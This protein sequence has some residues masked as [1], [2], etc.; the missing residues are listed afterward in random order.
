MVVVTA[1]LGAGCNAIFGIELGT[2]SSTSSGS[3]SSSSGGAGGGSSASSSGATGGNGSSTTTSS[4]SGSGGAGGAPACPVEKVP[5]CH[6]DGGAGPCD[7]IPLTELNAAYTLGMLVVG[8]YLYWASGDGKVT[9]VRFDGAMMEK[10]GAGN[11]SVF[12]AADAA[13]VYYTDWYDGT[14]RSAGLDPPH[15]LSDVTTVTGAMALA[16]LSRIALGD[17]KLY[18]STQ[19][20]DTLWS[21]DLGGVAANPTKVAD[22]MSDTSST[23]SAVGVAVDAQHV[24]WSDA[25]KVRRIPLAKLGDATA[26][27]DFAADPGAGEIALDGARVYWTSTAGV[28]SKLKDGTGLV[29]APTGADRARALLLD[30]AY[31]YWTADGGRV[32]RVKRGAADPVEVVGKGPPG[33]FGLAADCG[34]IYWSTFI[35]GNHGTVYKV[36]KPD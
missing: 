36:R 25:D 34:A 12:L 17:G 3:S 18:W 6:P 14:I 27:E 15:S 24:Y 9:R 1:T 10:F 8:D 20:P 16:R 31:V 32:L 2:L 21:Y 19:D 5:E 33:A 26:I 23:N 11:D 28:A 4:S 7:P 29:V 22:R 13:G 35:E 30:G